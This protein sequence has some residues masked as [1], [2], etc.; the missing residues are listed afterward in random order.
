[1]LLVE[2]FSL[3]RTLPLGFDLQEHVT[4]GHGISSGGKLLG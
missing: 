2:R 4:E 1:V 3:D